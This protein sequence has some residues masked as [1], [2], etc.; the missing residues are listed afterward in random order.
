MRHPQAPRLC[1]RDPRAIGYPEVSQCW[2]EKL[3]S[4]DTAAAIAKNKRDG[5][6]PEQPVSQISNRVINPSQRASKP[7]VC[8][9]R[10]A[11]DLKVHPL[12]FLGCAAPGSSCSGGAGRGWQEDGQVVFIKRFQLPIN[13]QAISKCQRKEQRESTAV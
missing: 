3:I 11:L 10:A 5:I 8:G 7:A 1:Q 9:V 13:I 2:N 6:L 4:R 12:P